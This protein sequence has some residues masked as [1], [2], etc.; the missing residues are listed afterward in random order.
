MGTKAVAC[1]VKKHSFSFALPGS[2]S[3]LIK[4]ASE[5]GCKLRSKRRQLLL[6]LLILLLYVYRKLQDPTEGVV[7]GKK[8]AFIQIA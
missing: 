4:Q 8:R 2:Q 6:S 7:G 3:V 5:P 1:L